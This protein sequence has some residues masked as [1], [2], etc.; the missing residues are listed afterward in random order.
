M[1]L[2]LEDLISW[3]I[4]IQFPENVCTVTFQIILPLLAL[5]SP[6]GSQSFTA[7][8]F[9]RLGLVSK[10]A[11][12]WDLSVPGK[13]LKKGKLRACPGWFLSHLRW[14]MIQKRNVGNG[15]S[16]FWEVLCCAFEAGQSW[17]FRTV[18]CAVQWKCDAAS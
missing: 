18:S 1:S 13:Q 10:E 2:T 8:G 14:C 17:L 15:L 11:E 12:E 6:S 3:F 4:F 9:S 7:E 5:I 16:F